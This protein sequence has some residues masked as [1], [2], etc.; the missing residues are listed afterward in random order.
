[1]HHRRPLRVRSRKKGKL[2]S[3]Q[4]YRL[5]AP[6]TGRIRRRQGRGRHSFAREMDRPATQRTHEPPAN[7]F[8]P[9]SCA[10]SDE[11]EPMASRSR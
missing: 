8:T 10:E 5:L 3:W 6:A 9:G 2:E 7:N 11:E 4:E 1:M